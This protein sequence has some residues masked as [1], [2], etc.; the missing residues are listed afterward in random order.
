MMFSTI[1]RYV[2][3]CFPD[4]EAGWRGESSSRYLT[5]PFQLTRIC[6][7]DQSGQS[8][9]D[10]SPTTGRV[11]ERYRRCSAKFAPSRKFH[12][13]SAR[14]DASKR[15]CQCS[16]AD[17]CH[18]SRALRNCGTPNKH[19]ATRQCSEDRSLESTSQC[20]QRDESGRATRAA[21][22]SSNRCET[23]QARTA[24]IS[25]KRNARCQPQRFLP[26]Q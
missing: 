20:E 11:H 13:T 1:L 9:D 26:L 2:C 21:P 24:R 17:T 12:G 3:I 25:S 4:A 22:W 5:K 16:K 8:D 15:T 6:E 10:V 19:G 23:C 7:T 18:N 14:D